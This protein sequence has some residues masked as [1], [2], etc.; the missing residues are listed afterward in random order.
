MLAYPA[1][2]GNALALSGR[3]IAALPSPPA[4]LVFR[5]SPLLNSFG[6]GG[7]LPPCLAIL[8][9]RTCDA[10]PPCVAP[11]VWHTSKI[12]TRGCL[13]GLQICEVQNRPHGGT[14]SMRPVPDLRG[15]CFLRHAR[16]S[17][18]FVRHFRLG[19]DPKRCQH[20]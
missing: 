4:R 18:V 6:S 19:L 20:V 10:G 1:K 13:T 8:R 7:V 16:R 3:N 14:S 15:L 5:L 9:P 17:R 11:L 2:F 12:I